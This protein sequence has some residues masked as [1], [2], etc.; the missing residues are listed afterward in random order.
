M[1]IGRKETTT[2]SDNRDFNAD[3]I[4]S[5]KEQ[6]AVHAAAGLPV[7]SFD[8]DLAAYGAGPAPEEPN[9]QNEPNKEP[10]VENKSETG[11]LEKTV[12]PVAAPAGVELKAEARAAAAAAK[13]AAPRVPPKPEDG[14]KAE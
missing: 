11:E 6:R 1:A 13:K 8:A 2:V 12:P 7:D 4:A 3:V 9:E 5:L 14:Q 10:Q